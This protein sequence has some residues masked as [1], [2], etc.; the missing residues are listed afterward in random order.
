MSKISF[1]KTGSDGFIQFRG[2][3]NNPVTFYTDATSTK[4][5]SV[6]VPFIP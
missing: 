2:T 3:L 1:G 4:A 5:G 6:G